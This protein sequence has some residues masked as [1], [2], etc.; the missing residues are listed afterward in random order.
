MVKE[1][2]QNPATFLNFVRIKIENHKKTNMGQ[3]N[4]NQTK[5]KKGWL[6]KLNG[7]VFEEENTEVKEE[8]STETSS[9]NSVS[10]TPSKFSYSDV[11]QNNPQNIPAN[12]G[13]PNANGVFDEKFYNSFLQVIE[14]NNIDG[15]DYFEFSRAKKA[16]DATPGFT[17]PMKYQTAFNTLKTFS[18]TP[19]LTK[20]HLIKTADFYLTKLAEEEKEFT[21]EMQHEVEAEVNSRLAQAKLKQDEITKKQEEIAKLQ[22]EMGQLQGEISSLNVEAQQ[23]QAKIDS[24]AKNF[25]VSL[26][27]L[28]GQ[29]ELDKQ[30]INAY[31]Q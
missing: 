12:L 21:N 5:P 11:S 18:S 24:T 16:N 7:L 14:A 15:M 23:V 28:R 22:A 3:E 9:Q 1:K 8:T 26:D 2:L 27:V 31:I 4:Q 20:E 6:S 10:N 25:K 19:V 29:I 17:E 30:N 13:I